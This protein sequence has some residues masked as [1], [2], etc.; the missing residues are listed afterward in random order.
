[1]IFNEI[2]LSNLLI[3]EEIRRPFTLPSDFVALETVKGYQ[4]FYKRKP[5][6]Y[7]IEVEIRVIDDT[8]KSVQETEEYLRSILYTD[9]PA[10]LELRDQPGRYNWAV[11]QSEL[12][13]INEYTGFAELEFRCF[14]P[15]T[16]SKNKQS[17]QVSQTNHIENK[18]RFETY[19]VFNLRP[20]STGNILIKSQAT[21]EQLKITGRY[22]PNNRLIIDCSNESVRLDNNNALELLSF[23]SDFFSLKKGWNTI[24]LTGATGTIEWRE[25]W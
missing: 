10:K 7:S 25:R 15:Y 1:M 8:F 21:Q 11:C 24:E 18:G 17:K 20:N 22:A 12:F 9:R 14:D 6:S 19:P 16:Y 3:V 2:N 5:I 13:E 4:R 23:E